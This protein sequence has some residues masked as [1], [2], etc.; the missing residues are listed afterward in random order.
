MDRRL[1]FIS[2]LHIRVLIVEST[3]LS[4]L[5]KIFRSEF[6]S[7]WGCQIILYDISWMNIS[8]WV[9]KVCFAFLFYLLLLIL[10]K[11]LLLF[12]GRGDRHSFLLQAISLEILITLLYVLETTGEG[13]AWAIHIGVPPPLFAFQKSLAKLEKLLII[14]ISFS[15]NFL[16]FIKDHVVLHSID[17]LLNILASFFLLRVYYVRYGLK[18]L[19]IV[20][21]LLANWCAR[22]LSDLYF[23]FFVVALG[24]G[25]VEEFARWLPLGLIIWS[26]HTEIC[27][28]HLV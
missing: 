26:H 17:L 4:V 23:R 21:L 24:V 9:D 12:F 8:V 27:I 22:V 15:L 11:R 5:T 28:T 10:F 3:H 1:L 2:Q 20:S 19:L 7:V 25:D 14:M 6:L 13:S 16:K 18:V